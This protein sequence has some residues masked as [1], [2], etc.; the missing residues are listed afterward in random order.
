MWLF[1]WGEPVKWGMWELV[2]IGWAAGR[3][4][5]GGRWTSRRLAL[6]LGSNVQTKWESREVGERC[7]VSYALNYRIPE[8]AASNGY[9]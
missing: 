2:Y 4:V 5:I 9:P 8:S 7:L 3:Y 6:G 1:F